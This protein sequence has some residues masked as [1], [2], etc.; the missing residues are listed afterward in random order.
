MEAR[1]SRQRLRRRIQL[2]LLALGAILVDDNAALAA[3]LDADNLH[4][5]EVVQ[6]RLEHGDHLAQDGELVVGQ[7]A[8][9]DGFVALAGLEALLQA[10]YERL[11]EDE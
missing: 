1:R 7:F 8:L 10:C 6:R 9:E 2:P 11:C 3:L 4:L 5:L